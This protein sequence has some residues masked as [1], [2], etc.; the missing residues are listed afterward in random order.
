MDSF[1]RERTKTGYEPAGALAVGRISAGGQD[2]G[3]WLEPFRATLEHTKTTTA[4]A[5]RA[6]HGTGLAAGRAVASQ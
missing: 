6:M 2:G 3:G 4:S 5:A 1:A